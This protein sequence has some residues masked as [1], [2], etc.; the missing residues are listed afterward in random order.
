LDDIETT[1]DDEL[2]TF[3]ETQEVTNIYF[4][5]EI[6][7]SDQF[8]A[9]WKLARY[10]S[11]KL[12]IDANDHLLLDF[13]LS[14]PISQLAS[15]MESQ[16]RFPADEHDDEETRGRAIAVEA[17][18]VLPEQSESNYG[19]EDEYELGGSDNEYQDTYSD[20][21]VSTGMRYGTA[22]RQVA[23]PSVS[24]DSMRRPVPR[25]NSSTMAPRSSQYP[26]SLQELIPS[27]RMMT[28]SVIQSASNFQISD[29]VV[30][31]APT[32]PRGE[33]SGLRLSLPIRTRNI[34]DDSGQ[35]PSADQV[36][37]VL[38]Q[39]E[40]NGHGNVPYAFRSAAGSAIQPRQR[41]GQL[42]AE[43]R[44]RN[45]PVT[46]LRYREIG[47][48]G[49]AFVLRLPSCILM[50]RA[51][52]WLQI[53]HLYRRRI[54]DWTY[55]NWTSRLRV[56]DG[57]P[58]F[59]GEERRF[60]DFTY[61]DRSGQMRRLL[62][63]VGVE[64]DAEWSSSTT[65]HLEVKTT[66]GPD[67]E[68]FFVSQNQVDLVSI[69]RVKG[70]PVRQL[71]VSRCAVIMMI[72][73]MST[74]YFGCPILKTGM[75]VLRFSPI[76]GVFIWVVFLILD[77]NMGMKCLEEAVRTRS[78]CRSKVPNTRRYCNLNYPVGR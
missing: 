75:E 45:Q 13:A 55:S 65:F 3:R 40:P 9:R 28:A 67:C 4:R 47:F 24:T 1:E 53:Y 5:E 44:T 74:S 21:E 60:A 22:D 49:E 69:L 37:S 20:S 51:N 15:F 58:R 66:L 78:T 23:V 8:M 29:S 2:V 56:E 77:R 38:S 41:F 61:R 54:D 39:R 33:H 35:G 68:P 64:L 73:T 26:Q 76:L 19:S 16:N 11:G 59:S 7:D 18:A 25:S 10:F 70:L 43:V 46:E 72:Q 42:L 50:L 62:R 63:E 52:Y 12:Q 32:Q 6:S 27:H 17:E 48:L 31:R 34:H 36:P 71:M 57:H 14:A 30:A